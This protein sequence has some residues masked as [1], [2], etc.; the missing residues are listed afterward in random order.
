MGKIMKVMVT[1]CL[2]DNLHCKTIQNIS[3]TIDEIKI[4]ES[5]RIIIKTIKEQVSPDTKIG[6]KI[7]LNAKPKLPCPKVPKIEKLRKKV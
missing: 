2:E 3:S 5:A 6:F 1:C 4:L 7:P